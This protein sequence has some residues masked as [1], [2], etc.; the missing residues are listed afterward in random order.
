MTVILVFNEEAFGIVC[1]V[2]FVAIAFVTYGD[3]CCEVLGFLEGELV[4]AGDEAFLSVE[5][6]RDVL[7]ELEM[8]SS[9]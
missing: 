6:G 3:I 8:E 5:R 4:N 2:V 9:S 1:R 7:E